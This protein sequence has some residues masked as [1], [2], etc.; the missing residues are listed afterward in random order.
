MDSD[1]MKIGLIADIHANLPALTAVLDDM[2][3][4]IDGL[5]CLGD[6]IGYYAWPAEC[7]TRIREACDLVVQ[8]NHD[9]EVTNPDSYDGNHMAIAGLKHAQTELSADQIAWLTELPAR[10]DAFE[11]QLLAVHS[12][13]ENIDRYVTK[14]MF[15]SVGTYMSELNQV[16][17]LGHTHQQA[18]VNMEKFDR[19]GWVVNPG[20]VGQ[21]R[22]NNPN[23]AYAVADLT[24]PMVTLHRVA[25]PI[26]EVQSA[27]EA[28]GLPQA[29]ASR[30]EEGK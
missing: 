15:T 8:G 9:R 21:P 1:L 6:I 26:G 25:Y 7:V 17:A 29:A 4:D 16:L 14:G 23:A 24:T 13:P 19:N 5:C 28:A 10:T 3:S 2:P 12:H 22:D 30:L 18:A 27:H 11:E 20:S